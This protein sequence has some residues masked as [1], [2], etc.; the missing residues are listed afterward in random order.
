MERE[1]L[2]SVVAMITIVLL[3]TLVLISLRWYGEN[4]LRVYP[5]HVRE[6]LRRAYQAFS[7]PRT[8]RICA[9]SAV[10]SPAAVNRCAMRPESWP[11][12]QRQH[13]LDRNS[14]ASNPICSHGRDMA[15]SGEKLAPAKKP[16]KEDDP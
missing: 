9:E 2:A 5:L 10:S 13:V 12:S 11:S 1:S 7:P 16:G 15:K 14:A 6:Q 3:L 8:D 4:R